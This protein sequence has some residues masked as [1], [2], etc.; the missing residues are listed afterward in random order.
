MGSPPGRWI[1]R[2]LFLFGVDDS[3]CVAVLVVWPFW[4]KIEY[5]D[6]PGFFG[7]SQYT[8]NSKSLWSFV[9]NLAGYNK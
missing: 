6:K 8:C 2:A 1:G 3:V 5:F 4:Q 9:N 7:Y